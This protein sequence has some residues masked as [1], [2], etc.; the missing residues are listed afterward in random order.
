MK[1][2][3]VHWSL[4]LCHYSKD[5]QIHKWLKLELRQMECVPLTSEKGKNAVK[6]W[7]S[8]MRRNMFSTTAATLLM[9]IR[10]QS[11][12]THL[13][14]PPIM[15]RFFLSQ[16][17]PGSLRRFSLVL[18][19]LLDFMRDVDSIVTI[20]WKDQNTWTLKSLL[21]SLLWIFAP[22]LVQLNSCK[23]H[24]FW[25]KK[26]QIRF[27]SCLNFSAKNS[28]TFSIVKSTKYLNFRAKISFFF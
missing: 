2:T 10:K 12:T 28:L 14:Q 8:R 27:M 9:S 26:I 6:V 18:N 5:N 24:N 22:K 16:K 3:H 20:N 15:Q 11:N 1:L 25:R 7:N 21:K 17:C 4:W 23:N 19:L 13:L